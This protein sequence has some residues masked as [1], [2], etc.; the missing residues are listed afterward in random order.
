MGAVLNPRNRHTSR[1]APSARRLWAS[2]RTRPLLTGQSLGPAILDLAGWGW[3]AEGTRGRSPGL[4]GKACLQLEPR[5]WR[6]PPNHAPGWPTGGRR[7]PGTRASG[8]GARGQR[9]LPVAVGCGEAASPGSRRPSEGQ[10]SGSVATAGAPNRPRPSRGLLQSAQAAARP[11]STWRR[12]DGRSVVPWGWA[13]EAAWVYPWADGRLSRPPPSRLAGSGDSGRSVG[14]RPQWM[15]PSSA[16]PAQ[17]G[18]CPDV[19]NS[20][21][22]A[23]GSKSPSCH[24]GLLC[25]HFRC[26]RWTPQLSPPP[27]RM[28]KCDSKA[29][30]CNDAFLLDL[31]NWWSI[32]F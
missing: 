29:C 26:G 5:K 23:P 16:S 11:G 32:C 30:K 15:E 12:S 14:Q 25:S 1:L 18:R 19:S 6:W 9:P 21:V 7:E 22:R 31:S 27:G 2:L 24:S 28:L 10:P 4:F 3:A 13:W 20:Q 8:A 17:R